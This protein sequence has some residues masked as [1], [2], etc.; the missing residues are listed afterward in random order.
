MYRK[1]CQLFNGGLYFLLFTV[2]FL[3]SMT[4]NYE[5]LDA[6]IVKN[7]ES[8]SHSQ[9]LN[10]EEFLASVENDAATISDFEKT[11]AQ[12][13]LIANTGAL[14]Q[15]FDKDFDL[16]SPSI[17][18][19]TVFLGLLETG[20]AFFSEQ[21]GNR[22]NRDRATNALDIDD[23]EPVNGKSIALN[24]RGNDET[25]IFDIEVSDIEK[26]FDH[27]IELV[28]SFVRSNDDVDNNSA[29]SSEVVSD[30]S[31]DTVLSNPSFANVELVFEK[32][33]SLYLALCDLFTNPWT[34]EW[35]KRSQISALLDH[36]AEW[37]G[38][39]NP[40]TLAT[41]DFSSLA[42]VDG[43]TLWY[44]D[45][46]LIQLGTNT[47]V[48]IFFGDRTLQNQVLF[49]KSKASLST[50]DSIDQLES[51]G[52][53]LALQYL[54]AQDQSLSTN[55][56]GYLERIAV[57]TKLFSDNRFVELQSLYYQTVF[58]FVI[59]QNNKDLWLSYLTA[60]VPDEWNGHPEY[61]CGS[62][63]W[64]IPTRFN[65]LHDKIKNFLWVE[66]KPWNSLY[67]KLEQAKSVLQ[68]EYH[69]SVINTVVDAV[70]QN[71][72]QWVIDQFMPFL[73]SIFGKQW[74]SSV[75]DVLWFFAWLDPSY[76][77]LQ[78]KFVGM[79]Q[80]DATQEAFLSSFLAT[81][82]NETKA[83][84]SHNFIL[85]QTSWSVPY[86]HLFASDWISSYLDM[87]FI[88]SY[89]LDK[90]HFVSIDPNLFEQV[91]NQK[92]FDSDGKYKRLYFLN[93]K[94]KRELVPD[95]KNSSVL[96]NDLIGFVV[97][98]V[99]QSKVGWLTAYLERHVARK[100]N[101]EANKD[102]KNTILYDGLQ[103][104]AAICT[105]WQKP[106]ALEWDGTKFWSIPMI[107][108]SSDLALDDV[109]QHVSGFDT[110]LGLSDYPDL[111]VKVSE[112]KKQVVYGAYHKTLDV[113]ALSENGADYCI[114]EPTKL[115]TF[116]IENSD[117]E[118]AVQWIS[119][120]PK[121]IDFSSDWFDVATV[122]ASADYQDFFTISETF[123]WKFL[124]YY[125]W[126][127]DLEPKPSSFWDLEQ[128]LHSWINALLLSKKDEDIVK[129]FLDDKGTMKS[130]ASFSV[131]SVGS[132]SQKSY[133]I[134][135]SLPDHG[136]LLLG[137]GWL[138][139]TS[140]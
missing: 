10:L 98:R 16:N 109:D 84:S 38:G 120:I 64:L 48:Y 42:V 78:E 56:Q 97:W 4:T 40:A 106:T 112:G 31:L 89:F 114:F 12:L 136:D 134:K 69:N 71:E 127:K 124:G 62:S 133:Q 18:D 51:L 58:D 94:W 96:D 44:G 19:L 21:S 27:M 91:I 45:R 101:P 116:H 137:F 24:A 93:S 50:F 32:N 72:L 90:S 20:K 63:L 22:Q 138:I 15:W 131:V 108:Q 39:Y 140:S 99:L 6:Y 59:A 11:L 67:D 52:W 60:I 82:V 85:S 111:H 118:S 66:Y 73:Q 34:L 119:A 80:L 47:P 121:A 35:E 5:S 113:S 77:V 57:P 135:L 75:Y 74:A 8:I 130:D 49:D 29:M 36:H 139:T 100:L 86:A 2:F 107:A 76:A 9:E 129:N 79:I 83:K 132:D 65:T 123:Y 30:L 3:L 26:A 95:W 128:A 117:E 103:W 17:T 1:Y 102:A 125:L 41:I 7:K 53:E 122:F 13:L 25:G 33:E 68:S 81:Y 54:L 61:L 37:F 110:S 126:Q 88:E 104:A 23:F 46:K 87:S 28:A 92:D 105:F 115:I 43:W 70:K 55:L 14:P